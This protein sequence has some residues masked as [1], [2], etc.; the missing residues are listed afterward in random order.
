MKTKR[1]FVILLCACLA[2]SLLPGTALADSVTTTDATGVT[3]TGATL[4]G[5]YTQ[6]A[7]PIIDR[8][9]K[10]WETAAPGTVSTMSMTGNPFSGTATMLT[11]NTS[12]SYC[13]YVNDGMEVQGATKTFTTMSDCLI[14][15]LN[16]H[17]ATGDPFLCVLDADIAQGTVCKI[18]HARFSYQ[19]Q[20]DAQW[21]DAGTVPVN[22][23]DI[24]TPYV[25]FLVEP[26]TGYDMRA[27]AS[28][29]G[30]QTWPLTVQ[31][32]VTIPHR[33]PEITGSTI[34]DIG[35]DSVLLRATTKDGSHP[36]GK[37]AS[38]IFVYRKSAGRPSATTSVAATG[39]SGNWSARI[40]GLARDTEYTFSVIAY[41]AAG[42]PLF[43]SLE[44]TFTTL[45]AIVPPTVA[46]GAADGI[47]ANGAMLHGTV[48]AGNRL[49]YETG[50]EIRAAGG[51]Y[52]AYPDASASVSLTRAADSLSAGDYEYRAY[53]V[54]GDGTY[55]GTAQTFAIKPAPTP[56]PTPTTAPTAAPTPDSA[57]SSPK[58]GDPSNP[59]LWMILA[60]ACAG[61][62]A[63]LLAL[64]R[65]KQRAR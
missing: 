1:F 35:T 5:A 39:G 14:G 7:N 61:T 17:V 53:A 54:T 31:K 4:G 13:A 20:G 45:A 52:T 63:V 43:S 6:G 37:V 41:T 36:N 3:E 22:P 42:T 48:T 2:L 65:R 56:T 33:D 26:G 21:T 19:K 27:E 46:T 8:G 51:S 40:S 47:T 58:T 30:G 60:C 55:Y 44:K 50:F 64:R 62:L 49:L 38:V 29:D 9:I 32:V 18:D 57:V 34:E 16:D 11:P 23:T 10:Y 12:Y 25:T 28:Y 24:R 59:A 15:P